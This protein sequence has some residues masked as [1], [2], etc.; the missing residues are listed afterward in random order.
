[1]P[2]VAVHEFALHPTSGE[3]VAATHGR[4]LWVLNVNPLRQ[5]TA[6]KL[7]AKAALY[8]PGPAV[9]WQDE[10]GR[11][12]WFSA[13]YRRFVGQNPPR[14]ALLYYSLTQK[15]ATTSIKVLDHTGKVVREMPAKTEPGLHRAVWD[16]VLREPPAKKPTAAEKK[17]ATPPS[18]KEEEPAEEVPFT[19]GEQPKQAPA[20][21]YRVVLTVDGMELTQ[22]L[23]V[24]PDPTKPEATTTTEAEKSPA[25]W[26][27]QR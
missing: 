2:T 3:I 13:S 15:A 12:A 20:G 11:G 23:R 1:L 27:K 5:I 7:R 14:G 16:L 18:E 22:W 4:S 8:E 24:E 17:P 6:E 9:K 10:P 19:F 21:M 26:R 25:L